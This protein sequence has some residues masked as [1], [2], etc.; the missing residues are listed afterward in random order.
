VHHIASNAL[1]LM[2]SG[3]GRTGSNIMSEGHHRRSYGPENGGQLRT[4]FN[5]TTLKTE[6]R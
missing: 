4:S 2:L 5:V 3:G 6:S 1:T